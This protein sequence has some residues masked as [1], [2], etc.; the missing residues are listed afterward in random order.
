MKQ[1]KPKFDYSLFAC[2]VGFVGIIVLL[3]VMLVTNGLKI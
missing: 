3:I 1:E 2:F